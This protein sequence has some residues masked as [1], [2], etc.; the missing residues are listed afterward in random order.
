V[1]RPT[2]EVSLRKP[3]KTLTTNQL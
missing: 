3:Q 2:Q 1:T